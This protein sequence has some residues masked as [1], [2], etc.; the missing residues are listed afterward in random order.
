MR[1]LIVTGDDFG[2]SR[3]VNLAIV[4]AH[5]RG[6]LTNASLMVSGDAASEAIALA[7]SRPGLSVGL[8]LVVADGRAALPASQIR[9]LVDGA[10]RF[11]A[12]LIRQGLRYQFSRGARSELAREVRA[13]LERFEETGLALSHVDGHHHMH[14]HPTVLQILLSL[15]DRFR[16][17]AIRLPHEELSLAVLLDRRG[18][19]SKVLSSL[20]FRLLRVRGQRRLAAAGI[21]VSDRVYGLLATGRITEDYLL[22]LIP[23]IRSNDV[24]L[25]CHPAAALPGER[26][27]GPPASG[28]E[29][30]AALLSERV[31]DALRRSRFVLARPAAARMRVVR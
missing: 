22:G 5:D 20:I 30:F 15:A 14:L 26:F 23:R 28:P 24:E 21:P 4:E 11:R 6:I 2:N 27:H 25:Y 3:E 29:E 9:R 8:H 16:I 12:G 17:P 19:P 18:V 31:K 1:R 7:R 10:G 13:Q